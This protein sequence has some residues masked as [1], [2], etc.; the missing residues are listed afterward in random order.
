MNKSIRITKGARDKV[1]HSNGSLTESVYSDV[2]IV[3]LCVSSSN[4]HYM[5]ALIQW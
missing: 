2:A 3:R 5:S 1:L 4:R